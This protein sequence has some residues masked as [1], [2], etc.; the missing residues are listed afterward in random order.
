MSGAPVLVTIGP[1]TLS[2]SA[3]GRLWGVT[4]QRARQACHILMGFCESCSAPRVTMRHCRKHADAW[5]VSERLRLRRVDA[6]RAAEAEGSRA[7]S[8]TGEETHV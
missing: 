4:R 3:W 6:A 1:R 7:A 2:I 8:R 5:N